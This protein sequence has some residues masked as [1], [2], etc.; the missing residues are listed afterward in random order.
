MCISAGKYWIAAVTVAGDVYVWDGKK[1]KEKPLI[2]TRLH[3]VKKATSVSVGETHLLIITSL[4]HP[5]YPPNMSKDHSMPKQK[6]KSDPDE[7]NEGFVFD[8]VES[9]E[10]LFISEKDNVKNHNAPTLKS[11]CE[12]ATAEHLL[13]PRN[14][15]QLL[16]IS[17]S[18]GAE[19]LRKHCEVFSY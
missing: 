13:E 12:M 10:V 8:E 19:D 18:I 11:L 15:M 14:A 16:E 3:G 5:V 1:G 4:Y 17:D 6:M 2:L 7:L 9:E